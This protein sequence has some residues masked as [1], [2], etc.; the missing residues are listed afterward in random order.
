M[1]KS[2]AAV[3][4]LSAVF[5]AAI[6]LSAFLLFQI[7]PLISKFILPWFG[8]SP[9]VWTTCMLFF[10]V[11]L[12]AGYSH[13]HVLT[14]L[15]GKWPGFI[16]IGLLV[17][18]LLCLPIAPDESW[19]PAGMEDP[20]G[21]ILLL[22]AATV[23]LPYFVLSATS[24]LVQVWFSRAFQ[25]VK[26][27]RLYALSNV[28]SLSALLSYPSFFE[29]RWDVLQQT[30]MWSGAFVLFAAL[31]AAVA[32]R[33]SRMNPSAEAAS[34][35][36]TADSHDAP[37]TWSRRLVWLALP[38]AGS[39]MLIATTNHVCQDVAVVP[40]LWVI[41]LSLYLLSFIICFDHERWYVAAVY[42]P[43]TAVAIF[44]ASGLYMLPWSWRPGFA[45]EL[46]VHFGAMFLACMLC[47]GELARLKPA[48]RH[49]TE[50]YLLM[51]AGGALGGVFVS[52]VAPRLFTTFFEWSLG[53]LGIFMLALGVWGREV[54]RR[55]PQAWRWPVGGASM[56]VGLCALWMIGNWEL[57]FS[58]K[59][60]RVRNFYGLASVT[61]HE[62]DDPRRNTLVFTSGGV[63][64]GKQY[65]AVELRREPLTYYGRHTGAG[66]A[67]APLKARPDARVGVVGMGIATLAAYA[68]PGQYYRFYEINPAVVGLARKWFSYL[69]DLEARGAT[70][71]VI[72]ADARLALERE[73]P[74]NFDV[75]IL[76]AFSGDS[77][78]AHLLT[79]EALEIYLRHLKP[80]GVIA[81]HIT[82][83][84]LNLAPVVQRLAKE[85]DFKSTPW[86]S[87]SDGDTNHMRTDYLL[88]SR[89]QAF[90]A[91][92][93][94]RPAPNARALEVP[95]WTDRYHNLFQILDRR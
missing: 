15:S 9:G 61:K 60:E 72:V 19:K 29:P 90:I 32:W 53:L 73:Q 83:R 48:P 41:P 16:H 17:A 2:T 3:S 34:L 47:H 92:H 71:D 42:A 4:G 10:Q 59:L 62:E 82:N 21:R 80:N 91:A 89:D 26:P 68:E 8:G 84:Y 64:H 49:L 81:V 88:L 66:Q 39:L 95:L 75:L 51:S 20:A 38:A 78:P 11:A 1:M 74:Q 37:P 36:G 56:L 93:P 23:G 94:A 55:F 76:D 52:L 85:F 14:R 86:H 24:P 25:G 87:P 45:E 63:I 77:V 35:L 69:A 22:L 58:S 30:W 44:V 57:T 31:L 54:W 50:Y 70:A 27:W 6:L 46:A 79:R 33:D 40:F 12:F 7:Q 43:L 18:A 67:L 5:A 65:E 28:G 13:A